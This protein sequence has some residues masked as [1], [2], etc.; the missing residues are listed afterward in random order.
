MLLKVMNLREFIYIGGR[1]MNVGDQVEVIGKRGVIVAL[2]QPGTRD[3][4]DYACSKTGGILMRF[5]DGDLQLWPSIDEDLLFIGSS[6][7]G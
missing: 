3:A 2:V 1:N 6:T 4:S 7:D 5:D